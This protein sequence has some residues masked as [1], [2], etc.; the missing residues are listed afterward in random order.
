MQRH[1]ACWPPSWLRSRRW[2][3]GL[4]V[5]PSTVAPVEPITADRG[6][7]ATKG[8]VIC[9]LFLAHNAFALHDIN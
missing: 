7:L 8:A 9:R 3:G 6:A 2:Q 5:L 4:P 1:G